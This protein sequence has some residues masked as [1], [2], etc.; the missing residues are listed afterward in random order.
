[1][2]QDVSKLVNR[3]KFLI[4][5]QLASS[6]FTPYFSFMFNFSGGLVGISCGIIGAYEV[7]MTDLNYALPLMQENS[8][9]NESLWNDRCKTIQ[10][11]ECDWFRPPPVSALFGNNNGPDVI[12]VA[13]CVWIAPLI[14]PLL[15]TLKTFVDD[16]TTVIITYQQRGKDAH[17]EFWEGIHNMFDVVI[18]DTEMTVGLAKPDVFH[19]LECKKR[20]T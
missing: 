4:A 12:L 14:A 3:D 16:S 13:D 20:I 6:P 5:Y 7:I 11:K 15:Q 19:V 17:D 1:L 2:G 10:C 9:R 18:V 8:N